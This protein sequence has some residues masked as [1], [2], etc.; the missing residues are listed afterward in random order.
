MAGNTYSNLLFRNVIRDSA[1]SVFYGMIRVEPDAQGTDAYQSNNNLML[2]D[3]A[4]AD[5]IPGLEIVANDVRCSH[6]ATVGQMDPEQVFYLQARGLP[7][8]EA[9]RLI[10]HG[11]FEP[12]TSRIPLEEIREKM[13]DLLD[14][15]FGR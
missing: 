9:E 10:V 13:S 4:R 2:S 3:T 14:E 6:G 8:R 5:T 7:R 15:R 11:F 1:R 12:V